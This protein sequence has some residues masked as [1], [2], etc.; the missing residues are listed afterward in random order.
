MPNDNRQSIHT[1]IC[2]YML[3]ALPCLMLNAAYARESWPEFRGPSGQGHVTTKGL[4]STWSETENVTWKTPIPGSG[5]SSPVIDRGQIWLTTS[6]HITLTGAEREARV[7]GLVNPRSLSAV[8]DLRLRAICVDQKSGKIL[9]DIELLTP[10]NPPPIHNLNSHASPTPVIE[11]GRLYTHFGTHGTVCIDTKSGKAIWKNTSLPVTHNNGP[12]S[13]IVLWKNNVIFHADGSDIQYIVALDKRT[14]DIAWKTDRTGKLNQN[15]D[16]KKAY[17]TPLIT[18]IHG[19]DQ[20]VSPASDWLYGYDPVTGEELWKLSY[21]T[22]G[23][24]I[25]PRPVAG[26]GMVFFSTSFNT[27]EILAVRFQDADG[28]CEPALAWRYKRGAPSQPSPLL[29]GSELYIVNDR[30]GVATCLDALTGKELWKERVGGSYSASPTHADGRIF[31]SNREGETTVLE[32][33]RTPKQ[34]ARNKLDGRHMA[35][36]AAVDGAFF[37]RTDKALYRIEETTR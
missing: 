6:T 15:P 28:D 16:F 33:G 37:I 20:L 1:R 27:A 31:F 30:S 19:R 4:P 13:S 29:V 3:A 25:V 36:F 10:E 8:D 35:S 21:E 17:G 11:K 23:F 2:F 9:H 26:H 18:K 14:G 7:K 22:L 5:W 34:L 12:G 32:A 24:S